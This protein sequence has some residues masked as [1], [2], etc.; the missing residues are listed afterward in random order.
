M[1]AV[2]VLTLAALVATGA[3]VASAGVAACTP[4]GFV[5]DTINLTARMINPPGT[6]SGTVD[7]TGCNIGV[8]YG[9]GHTGTVS[10]ADVFGANYFGIVNDGGTVGINH[11]SVH[12]IGE[13]PLN[14]TQHGNAIY[15]AVDDPGAAGSI[16]HNHVWNYQKNGITDTSA[17]H[18][19]AINHNVVNGEGPV[20]YI[21]QN[22]IEVGFGATATVTH[23]TVTGNSYTGAGGAS[24]GGIL[25][26]GGAC[27]SRPASVGVRINHNTLRGNDVGVFLA[28]L[29]STCAASDGDP[30]PERRLAQ[31]DQ[32]LRGQ[33]HERQRP[34]GPALPGRRVRRRRSRLDQPQPASAGSGTSRWRPRRRSCS[35]STRRSQSTRG[36]RTTTAAEPSIPVTGNLRRAVRDYAAAAGAGRV[37]SGRPGDAGDDQHHQRGEC[38]RDGGD[39]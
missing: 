30:D 4:T 16:T 26:V 9:P 27:F 23:N 22:G 29:D 1:V 14:G 12:D 28:N 24:S 35:A 10:H 7:A 8:Y 15:F 2:L 39:A 25:V 21:A 11:S 5:R 31:H 18:R 17:G 32:E 3:P 13:T 20:D 37:A 34:I 33:Q 6:V 38:S 36:C 19:V